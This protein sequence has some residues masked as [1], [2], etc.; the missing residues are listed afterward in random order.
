MRTRILLLYI[1]CQSAFTFSQDGAF[2]GYLFSI[3]FE[4]FQPK[5]S[6]DSIVSVTFYRNTT[7]L[8]KPHDRSTGTMQLI[9]NDLDSAHFKL[10]EGH[11]FI[12]SSPRT[13]TPPTLFISIEIARNFEDGTRMYYVK[14]IPII[15]A[16]PLENFAQI[17]LTEVKIRSHLG[18]SKDEIAIQVLSETTF[19]IVDQSNLDPKPAMQTLLRFEKK[20][21][22]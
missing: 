15:F 10:T 1:V 4:Q 17:D 7:A 3:Q 19:E 16:V 9:K 2:E 5:E 20:V 14:T 21:E 22:D 12:G 8:P 18:V 6:S 13:I 11:S